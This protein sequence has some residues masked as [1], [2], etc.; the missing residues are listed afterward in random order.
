MWKLP[1]DDGVK[2][3]AGPKVSRSRDGNAPHRAADAAHTLAK[4]TAA[5]CRYIDSET[6]QFFPSPNSSMFN[7]AWLSALSASK[8]SRPWGIP[9][10][11]VLVVAVIKKLPKYRRARNRSQRD[12]CSGNGNYGKMSSAYDA[13]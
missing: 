8:K 13:D 11:V 2:G 7:L 3:Q 9:K 12:V 10:V 5:A 4:N 6:N 1:P